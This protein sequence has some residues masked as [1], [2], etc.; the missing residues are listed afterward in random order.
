MTIRPFAQGRD[1]D[2]LQAKDS[3]NCPG[4]ELTQSVELPAI[5]PVLSVAIWT[6][7]GTE[8]PNT[9]ARALAKYV[10]PIPGG[11]LKALMACDGHAPSQR[12]RCGAEPRS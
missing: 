6:T 5:E 3:N 7:S 1:K 4:D 2:L 11:P 10:L 9:R 12:F 8:T